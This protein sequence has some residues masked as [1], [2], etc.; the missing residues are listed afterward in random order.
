M[1]TTRIVVV[2]MRKKKK[3]MNSEKYNNI[4]LL[5]PISTPPTNVFHGVVGNK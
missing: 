5:L 4:S 2:M 3:R 1:Y